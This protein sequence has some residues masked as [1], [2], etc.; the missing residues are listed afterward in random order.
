MLKLPNRP[1]AIFA[2]N[3]FMAVGA[4][5][6]LKEAGIKIPGDMALFSLT[7][8]MI[9]KSFPFQIIVLLAGLQAIP[10]DL[11]EATEVACLTS[12]QLTVRVAKT[13]KWSV[14]FIDGEKPIA[15]SVGRGGGF[16]D[17]PD[18]RFMSQTLGLGVGENVYGLGERFTP[19]VKPNHYPQV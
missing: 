16:L 14:E 2:Y 4:I 7:V 17:T 13:G 18:G 12:G 5:K 19:F 9:W 3:D 8:V 10:G 6:A 15:R 1:T 11:Y